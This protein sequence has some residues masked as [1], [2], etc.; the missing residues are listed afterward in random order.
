MIQLNEFI[1]SSFSTEHTFSK[2][3]NFN[4]ETGYKI[5]CFCFAGWHI[6]N[7]AM[8][9]KRGIVQYIS[10]VDS[11]IRI[12]LL[13]KINFRNLIRAKR[14]FNL[15]INYHETVNQIFF[16]AHDVEPVRYK[17]CGGL[18]ILPDGKIIQIVYL[19]LD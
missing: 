1:R 4:N 9:R 13:M 11:F 3:L 2:I 19:M 10:I 7:R 8:L 5:S 14:S 17:A 16:M 12:I 6:S 15:K 18:F